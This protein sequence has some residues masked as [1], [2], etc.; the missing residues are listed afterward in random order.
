M[1]IQI[2]NGPNLNLLGVR[3][4]SV[5]GSTSF[6]DFLPRLRAC[7]P[8]VQIDYFQ[9]NIEGELI[10]KLQDVGF[11]CDGIVLNAGAYTHTSIALADCIRAISA[12]VVE[13]HISNVHQ[14]EAFRHQSMIA[15]ACR[16]V[17]CGFGLD[18]YRLAIESFKP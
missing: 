11:Q 1:T 14:R 5:Y 8:D 7:F 9:S 2:I 16:G 3:E 15:A 18:S 4:P 13:V 17:I 10:D 12:P 6:D